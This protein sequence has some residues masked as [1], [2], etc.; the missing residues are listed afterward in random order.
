MAFQKDQAFAAEPPGQFGEYVDTF[1]SQTGQ[2]RADLFRVRRTVIAHV[3]F[4]TGLEPDKVTD[5]YVGELWGYAREHGFAD[6]FRVV[7][8]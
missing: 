3:W 5:P 7:L 4:P 2:V 1:V 6:H 8:S